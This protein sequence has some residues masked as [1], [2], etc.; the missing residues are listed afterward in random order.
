MPYTITVT[1]LTRYRLHVARR[2]ESTWNREPLFDIASQ[3]AGWEGPKPKVHDDVIDV[4][5]LP[6]SWQRKRITDEF[7]ANP[8]EVPK[9]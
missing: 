2:A 5:D 1:L 4:E 8:V 9:L 6:V 7:D 3:I